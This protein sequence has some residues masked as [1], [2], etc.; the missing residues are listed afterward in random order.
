MALPSLRKDLRVLQIIPA[1]GWY[2]SYDVPLSGGLGEK[3]RPLVCWA[4]VERSAEDHRGQ[5][6]SEQ[7]DIIPFVW[8]PEGFVD[9]ADQS[10][11]F[12]SCGREEK[13][14]DGY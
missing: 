11:A 13:V 4:L 1:D 5:V 6:T 2:A 3:R 9:E 8:N 12:V 14:A 7:Q 10:D